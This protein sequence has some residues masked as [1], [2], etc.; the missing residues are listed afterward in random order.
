MDDDIIQAYLWQKVVRLGFS[1][2]KDRDI[3]SWLYQY[4]MSLPDFWETEEYPKIGGAKRGF[5]IKVNFH[6]INISFDCSITNLKNF[7]VSF[8]HLANEP[9]LMWAHHVDHKYFAFPSQSVL[10][11]MGKEP[12]AISKISKSA[13]HLERV[14][15]GLIFHPRTHQHIESPINDHVI[16]IGGGIYNP[17][18]FLL[19]LRYQLCLDMNRRQKEKEYLVDLFESA[20]K[21]KETT[22]AANTLLSGGKT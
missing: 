4:N 10:N 21:N 1:P 9:G 17:F 12:Q 14:L 2:S 19:H 5:Q 16:R 20:I 3:K 13:P 11:K 22:V 7:A 6:Q 8:S 15:D 18:V